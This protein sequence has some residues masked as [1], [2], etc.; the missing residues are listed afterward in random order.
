MRK[1]LFEGLIRA[2]LSERP[3]SPEETAF[4]ELATSLERA[5]RRRHWRS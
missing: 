4:D 5:A 1:L 2:P 3:P